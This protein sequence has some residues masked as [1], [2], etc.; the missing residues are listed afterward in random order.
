MHESMLARK[1]KL[2]SQCTLTNGKPKRPKEVGGVKSS[3]AV[4]GSCPGV[5][6]LES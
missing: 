3:R 6:P 1:R 5:L 2:A 4:E